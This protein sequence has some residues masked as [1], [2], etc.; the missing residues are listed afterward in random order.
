MDKLSSQCIDESYLIKSLIMRNTQLVNSVKN[1]LNSIILQLISLGASDLD[2]LSNDT[3]KLGN[4]GNKTPLNKL[5]YIMDEG[6]S[7]RVKLT[8]IENCLENNPEILINYIMENPY[9]L[10]YV[11]K[12][13]DNL[14]R[15]IKLANNI[16]MDFLITFILKQNKEYSKKKREITRKSIMTNLLSKKCEYPFD[17]LNEPLSSIEKRLLGTRLS[18]INKP[19]IGACK[20]LPIIMEFEPANS[21]M[22]EGYCVVS[23]ISGHSIVAFQLVLL[24]GY[25]WQNM[26]IALCVNMVPIHHSIIEIFDV[27]M[28]YG[29][30]SHY[31]YKGFKSSRQILEFVINQ[32]EF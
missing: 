16:N 22:R 9:N 2:F 11:S 25:D 6:T 15:E 14:M 3:S 29:L 19:I 21:R 1:Y 10:E 27:V 32:T 31:K 28:D 7:I 24:L 23:G 12:F 20:Y 4:I 13:R 17:L 30:V 8:A 26:F 18:S 5:D